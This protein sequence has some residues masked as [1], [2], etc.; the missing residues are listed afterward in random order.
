LNFRSTHG[1]NNDFFKRVVLHSR[2]DPP[3]VDIRA[4]PKDPVFSVLEDA[5]QG[6]GGHQTMKYLQI[7]RY[8]EMNKR[9][10][11]VRG[12]L[13]QQREELRTVGEQLG[14][15]VAKVKGRAL[16]PVCEASHLRAGRVPYLRAWGAPYLRAEGAPYLRA[17]GAP[18]LR[19]WGAPY[20]RAEGAITSGLGEHL[21]SGLGEHLNSGLGS[22]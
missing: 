20:S 15:S 12:E 2:P 6:I 16:E 14:I 3:T 10:Q 4:F 5:N 7:C 8:L 11:E 17:W 22:T 19:A 18:N 9:L 1:H 21:T 13:V